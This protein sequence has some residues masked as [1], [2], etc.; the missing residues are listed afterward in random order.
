ML[1]REYLICHSLILPG[2]YFTNAFLKRMGFP[3][4][5]LITSVLALSGGH[6][7][8][9]RS[10]PD[11]S[12]IWI[13]RGLLSFSSSC[14][15]RSRYSPMLSIGITLGIWA[16]LIGLYTRSGFFERI[17]LRFM[18]QPDLVFRISFTRFGKIMVNHHSTDFIVAMKFE[19]RG[20]QMCRVFRR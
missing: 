19:M 15:P 2:K 1:H 7:V 17:Y 9:T 13:C 16:I 10:W 5:A 12:L 14:E 3:I 18:V 11:P 6:K 4:M 20:I 8:H